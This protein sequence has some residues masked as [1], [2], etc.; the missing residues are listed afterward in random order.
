[1]LRIIILSAVRSLLKYRNITFINLFGLILGLTSFLFTLHYLVY[2]F[3]YDSFINDSD[4]VYR[5]NLRIEKEGQTVYH[6]AK[7][8]RALFFALKREIPEVEANGIAYFE[9][10]LVNFESTNYANQ[11]VLWVDEGFE[12]VFPLK[13]VAGKADYSRPGLGT[14]S[15]T[16]AK[17]L[18]G[19][20]DPIGQIMKV[21]QGMPIEITGIFEDL[22][23]NTHLSAGYFASIKTWVEMG[24]I[25]EAGDWRWNGWWNYIRIKSGSSH[26]QTEAKINGFVDTYMGFL[27]DDNRKGRFTLQPL[28]DL[29]YISGI[30]GE[31][32]ATT[33]Y[34]SLINLIV[35]ALVTLFIAWINYV[36]LSTAHA[37]SRTLQIGMRKL[38]GASDIH[39]WHQSLTE[40]FILNALA[41]IVSFIVYLLL[42]SAFA[43]AFQAPLLQAHLPAHYIVG[44]VLVVLVAG[45]LFSS[46]FHGIELAKIHLWSAKKKYKTGTFK[47]GLVI[48]QMALSILFLVCTFVVY[49]QIAYMKNKDLGIALDK[50]IVCTGPA[51]LNADPLKRQRFEGFKSELLGY[52]GFEAATFNLYAPGQE[53]RTGFREMYSPAQGI[54][55]DVLFFEN[56]GSEGLVETYQM[57]LLAGKGFSHDTDQNIDKII[58]NEAGMKMLGFGSPEESIGQ[59][60]FRKGEDST[61]LEVLGVVADFHNEGLQKPIYPMVWNNE[62]PREF[63]YFALRVNTQNARETID[64]LKTVWDQHYPKDNLDFV[65]ANDQ[66]NNQYE[67]ES[68]FGKFYLWLTL[69]SIGIATMGLYGLILFYLDKRNREIGIRKVNGATIQEVMLLLNR[70]FVRWVVIAFLIATPIA[71]YAMH[72][73]LD[74][75]AYKTELSW[76]IFVLAGMLALGIALLTV[77]FQS[78]KAAIRNPVE[79]LRY[80]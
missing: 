48:A 51:S 15:A 16:K 24:A 45:V 71:W 21:N 58:I 6:G 10:C 36:N 33:N 69:L 57:K 47:K 32:G 67:S 70:D 73:W 28:S 29:H 63:G 65:F 14:I 35:I 13:M 68:R 25:S 7:T 62:Y 39:L 53:P 43:Q 66:F 31:M 75:F 54:M 76:W 17:A 26:K 41:V 18:F 77:S 74:H 72:T 2:E 55:P 12:D 60:V 20:V 4:H 9:K 23:S 22:P 49:K 37:H 19:A 50:V 78:Y 61:R 8:P 64:R 38:I 34:S 46:I 59:W 11:D 44:I 79:S 56:N 42:L 5:V 80:E 52:A 30:E 40:S 27:T 3:S 1:M